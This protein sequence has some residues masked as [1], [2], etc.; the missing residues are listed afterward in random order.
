MT[1][2]IGRELDRIELRQIKM[3][4]ILDLLL[5]LKNIFLLALQIISVLSIFFSKERKEKMR[6][7]IERLKQEPQ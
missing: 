6:A 7:A 3:L 4:P 1:R 2:E 5:E